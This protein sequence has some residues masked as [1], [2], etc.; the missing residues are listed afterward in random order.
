M[1]TG[2]LRLF[3]TTSVLSLLPLA[4]F[5]KICT[6]ADIRAQV[7]AAL[8]FDYEGEGCENAGG[9]IEIAATINIM[10]SDVV[11]D[12]KDKM[13]L[14]WIGPGECNKK[15]TNHAV[16]TIK[17]SRVTLRNFSVLGAPDGLHVNSGDASVIDHVVFPYVCEDAITN[18][19]KKPNSAT[20]TVIKNSYFMNSD[21][22]AIQ[23]NGGSVR[24]DNCS[25]KNVFRSIGACAEKADPG[26]HDVGECPVPTHIEATGNVI[27]SCRGYAM[28]AAGK[29]EKGA[30]GTLRAIGNRFSNCAPAIQ[31]EESGQVYAA[32]NVVDGQC[33]YLFRTLADGKI[34]ACGNTYS[35]KA[36]KA[37]GS[38]VTEKCE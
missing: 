15:P 26:W 1:S 24:V 34:Q 31:A 13:K 7:G 16:F 14:V 38:D 5:A 18:G 20:N 9:K 17:A 29:A 23:V 37:S 8:P 35:C 27:D 30:A 25:F 22:K 2:F 21:D 32:Y 4:A 10:K 28:R 33:D 6:E 11:V 3:A 12:G 36:W 19:N